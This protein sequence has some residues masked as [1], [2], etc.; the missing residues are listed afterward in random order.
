M[1]EYR[2]NGSALRELRL[3][4]GMTTESLARDAGLTSNYVNRLENSES[5]V[6][7]HT[8][9]ALAR[10]LKRNPTKLVVKVEV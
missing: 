1:H 8:L 7:V 2:L 3:E 4:R 10:V 9:F 5:A 6:K